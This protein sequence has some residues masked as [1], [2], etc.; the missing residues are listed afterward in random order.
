MMASSSTSSSSSPVGY[1]LS[2]LALGDSLTEGHCRGG[3]HFAPYTDRLRALIE[4]KFDSEGLPNVKVYMVN[5][6]ISGELTR[7]M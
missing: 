4:A 7:E 6:G 2:I 1:S 5:E 3:C